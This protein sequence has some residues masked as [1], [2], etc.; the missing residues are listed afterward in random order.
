M[1]V[2]D[3]AREDRANET[4]VYCIAYVFDDFIII[5]ICPFTCSRGFKAFL[6]TCVD[7]SVPISLEK[8]CGFL[9]TITYLGYELDSCKMES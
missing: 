4:G 3:G 8:M 1:C 9:Q 7:I 2:F 6:S 5:N